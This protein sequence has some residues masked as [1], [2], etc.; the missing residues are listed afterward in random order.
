[1]SNESRD[2]YHE[3]GYLVLS[4]RCGFRCEAVSQIRDLNLTLSV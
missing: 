2:H 3:D 4:P 1:M